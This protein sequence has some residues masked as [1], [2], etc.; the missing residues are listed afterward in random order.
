MVGRLAASLLV[1]G[2]Q[3]NWIAQDLDGY[4]AIATQL[5]REGL[6]DAEKRLTLRS[7]L[8]DSALADGLTEP[9]TR[10]AI[11]RSATKGQALLSICAF[12]WLNASSK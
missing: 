12:I 8:Q 9:R 7:E 10:N 5:A 11:L 6:R 3:G 2:N 1:H 4:V